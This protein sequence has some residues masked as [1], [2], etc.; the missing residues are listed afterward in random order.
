MWLH[1]RRHDKIKDGICLHYAVV[2]FMPHQRLNLAQ[3]W[4]CLD[5]LPSSA[6]KL[7]W[8]HTLQPNK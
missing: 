3:R 8:S 5:G 6:A 1:A 2:I 7:P 4:S